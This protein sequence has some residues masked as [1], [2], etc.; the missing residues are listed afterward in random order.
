MNENNKLSSAHH[1][2]LHFALFNAKTPLLKV[3]ENLNKKSV[4]Y[5]ACVGFK[6]TVGPF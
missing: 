6:R 1:V 2:H 4:R 3:V 5:S